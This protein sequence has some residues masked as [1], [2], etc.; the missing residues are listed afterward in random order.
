MPLERLF[1]E[2]GM[3]EAV[4][5][6]AVLVPGG[7]AGE[8]VASGEADLVLQQVSEILVVKGVVL[9]GMLPDAIQNLTTYAAGVSARS[10][11]AEAAKAFVAALASADAAELMR[12]KRMLPAR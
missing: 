2:F 8:R 11:S 1:R 6:K 9:A 7:L 5:D 12:A 10:N 4:R 3:A